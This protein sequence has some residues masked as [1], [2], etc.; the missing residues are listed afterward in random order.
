MESELLTLIRE[1]ETLRDENIV[2]KEKLTKNKSNKLIFDQYKKLCNRM[3]KQLKYHAGSKN[4]FVSSKCQKLVDEFIALKENEKS[5][6]ERILLTERDQEI[7]FNEINNPSKPNVELVE[8][9]REHINK[10]NLT[11]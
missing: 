7:F 8:A 5:E 6:R 9:M 4:E 3:F 11:R 2:L 1:V 10:M